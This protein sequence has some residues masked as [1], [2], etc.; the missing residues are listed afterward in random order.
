MKS[1]R[2]RSGDTVE[3]Q[4]WIDN[5]KERKWSDGKGRVSVKWV[6]WRGRHWADMRIMRRTDEGYVHS[7][8][9]FRLTT[10]QLRELLPVLHEMLD[11]I[12]N[13]EEEEKRQAESI[14][15]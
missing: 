7:A 14:E 5:S 13:Q 8:K 6:S 15:D 9:G 1:V 2:I 12:D 11:H 10:K 3:K 4:Y